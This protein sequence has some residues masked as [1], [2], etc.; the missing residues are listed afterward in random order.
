M[1][2]FQNKFPSPKKQSQQEFVDKSGLKGGIR[3]TDKQD[4]P[5]RRR[6]WVIAIIINLVILAVLGGMIGSGEQD[7][8]P[9]TIELLPPEITDGEIAMNS[10]TPDVGTPQ[11]KAG[12]RDVSPTSVPEPSLETLPDPAI[13]PPPPQPLPP[14]PPEVKP[15]P[16]PPPETALAEPELEVKPE[17][18]PTEVVEAPPEEPVEAPPEPPAEKVE[19]TPP[20]AEL[21]EKPNEKPEEIPDQMANQFDSV[22]K[23]LTQNEQRER[24]SDTDGD[25]LNLQQQLLAE[26]TEPGLGSRLGRIQASSWTKGVQQQ[27]IRCWR[28]PA[29]LEGL[30][31]MQVQIKVFVRQDRTVERA[32]IVPTPRLQSDGAYQAFADSALRAVLNPTCSPLEVPPEGYE[33]W[34]VFTLN[35][36]PRDVF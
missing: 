34:K 8:K 33:T 26:N 23:N 17:E 20:P 10:S 3:Q 12:N 2:I 16:P 7:S 22:L 19:E 29:G 27:I 32:E 14:K 9:I 1:A 4:A 13:A 21:L 24:K 25:F 36:D 6:S 28:V 11:M 15:A 30:Q 35:F 5:V 31:T 18:T